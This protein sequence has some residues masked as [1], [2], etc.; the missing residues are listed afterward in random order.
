MLLVMWAFQF[1]FSPGL[2]YLVL[3]APTT[4]GLLLPFRRF[5]PSPE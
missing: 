1:V 5:F 4:T 3:A 2:T